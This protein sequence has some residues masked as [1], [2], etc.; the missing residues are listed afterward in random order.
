MTPSITKYIQVNVKSSFSELQSNI[1]L[2]EFFFTYHV[3]IENNSEHTVQLLSRKWLITDSNGQN[4][5]VEGE[6]V[7]GEQPILGP[8]QS[9]EYYSGCL[10]NTGFGKMKG[11]YMFQTLPG[12]DLFDVEI[13]EFNMVLPWVMN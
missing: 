1:E 6:G 9:Y 7:V 11:F 12:F 4:R 3:R 2:N 10:L 8:G 5:F 13:P